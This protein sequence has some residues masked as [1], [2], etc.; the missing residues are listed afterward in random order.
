MPEKYSSGEALLATND[1]ILRFLEKYKQ[2]T[3]QKDGS[4]PFFLDVVR[5]GVIHA[6][7]PAQN[8]QTL[9]AAN[10]KKMRASLAVF[11]Q[12]QFELEG[13]TTQPMVKDSV[14]IKGL[15]NAI[16]AETPFTEAR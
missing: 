15:I 2:G 8:K 4:A 1:R 11:Q 12:H 14:R 3:I 16:T 7:R 9:S 13:I 10:A 5:A 6:P